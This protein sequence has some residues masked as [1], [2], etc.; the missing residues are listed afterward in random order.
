MSNDKS[1]LRE[2]FF[3]DSFGVT[4]DVESSRSFS[5]KTHILCERLGKHK[6]N[7][8]VNEHADHCGVSLKTSSG[9]ALISGVEE[10][11]KSSFF[12]DCSYLSPL[13]EGGVNSGRVV[14]ASME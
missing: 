13:V 10:G 4:N 12:D 1:D 8:H 6:L 7:A 5:I 11:E 3:G 2:R 14:S 9:E